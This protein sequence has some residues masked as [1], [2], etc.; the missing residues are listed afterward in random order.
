MYMVGKDAKTNNILEYIDSCSMCK[1]VIINSGIEKLIVRD[2]LSKKG[3]KEINI[4]DW[5][6]YDEVLESKIKPL[7]EKGV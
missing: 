3:Y 6:E 7:I 1:R 2:I 5:I 4:K